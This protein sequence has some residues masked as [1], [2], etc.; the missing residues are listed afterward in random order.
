VKLELDKVFQTEL[1]GVESDLL[2]SDLHQFLPMSLLHEFR[3]EQGDQWQDGVHVLHSLIQGNEG[4]PALHFFV[5]GEHWVALLLL[6]VLQQKL[7]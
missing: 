4:F 2:F 7:E 1:G 6:H 3:V 5:L